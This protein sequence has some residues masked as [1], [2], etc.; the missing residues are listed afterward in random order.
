MHIH[1]LL[2]SFRANPGDT[3]Q[4]LRVTRWY[5][6]PHNP[7]LTQRGEESIRQ[8]SSESNVFLPPSI[9][10]FLLRNM[11]VRISRPHLSTDT[12]FAILD[13]MPEP[14]ALR[15]WLS[16]LIKQQKPHYRRDPLLPSTDQ[17]VLIAAGSLMSRLPAQSSTSCG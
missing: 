16:S 15:A 5:I 13:K 4:S 12:I 7:G 1:C 8:A 10:A 9:S 6:A 2:C 11:H 3:A 14:L 17:A